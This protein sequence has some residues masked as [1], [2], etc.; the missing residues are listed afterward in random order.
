MVDYL[1]F[2][3]IQSA[4]ALR[5]EYFQQHGTILL[6]FPAPCY[7][8][9][10]SQPIQALSLHDERTQ[11]GNGGFTAFVQCIC[12]SKKLSSCSAGGPTAQAFPTGELPKLLEAA[13][14]LPCAR[15]IWANSGQIIVTLPG[16][17]APKTL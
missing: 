4:K 5:D 17:S 9:A 13:A 6:M 1:G 3:S 7:I 15:K 16:A 8:A 2:D 10:P 11:R 12:Y 14:S